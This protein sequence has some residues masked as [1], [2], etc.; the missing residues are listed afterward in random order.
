MLCYVPFGGTKSP[1]PSLMA[2]CSNARGGEGEGASRPPCTTHASGQSTMYKASRLIYSS[3]AYFRY[4]QRT[5]CALLQAIL[6]TRRFLRFMYITDHTLD[7]YSVLFRQRSKQLAIIAILWF[8]FVSIVTA[9]VTLVSCLIFQS[10]LQC[11]LHSIS[12]PP[13]IRYYNWTETHCVHQEY[14]V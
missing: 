7:M 12:Q 4:I 8:V 9:S 5:G 11:S 6:A 1:G 2:M 10:I 14:R 3:L 13:H